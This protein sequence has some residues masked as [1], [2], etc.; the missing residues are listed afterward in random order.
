MGFGGAILEMAWWIPAA[1]AAAL[2]IV[3]QWGIP[4]LPLANPAMAGILK[5]LGFSIAAGLAGFAGFLVYSQ[6][7]RPKPSAAVRLLNPHPEYSQPKLAS[8][9][10]LF[11][12]ESDQSVP[13][14]SETELAA[15]AELPPTPVSLSTTVWSLD[16]L[17]QM[18]LKQLED[19]VAACF[20]EEGYRTETDSHA[21]ESGIDIRL[22]EKGKTETYAMVRCTA[23]NAEQVGVRVVRELL[24]A[25]T[26]ERLPR[27]IHVTTGS[28][29]QEAS[30]FAKQH[31]IVLIT[32]ELLL[33]DILHY[34]DYGKA[35]LTNA[36]QEAGMVTTSPPS[37]ET[38]AAVPPAI[39][40]SLGEPEIPA[41]E[42]EFNRDVK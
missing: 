28:Y 5:A 6:R 26:H 20:R 22:F 2:Y 14:A 17:R 24:G 30:D 9:Q 23:C 41:L 11:A 12:V 3:V 16:L 1:L 38:A 29:T 18:D 39:E 35:R 19:L 33:D 31:P 10:K 42:F 37:P 40:A 7:K 34:S 21:G 27:G 15:S 8:S 25:I 32:G 4:A 13:R 36:L